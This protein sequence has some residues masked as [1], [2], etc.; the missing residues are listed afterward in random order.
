MH[1]SVPAARGSAVRSPTATEGESVPS[2]AA[3]LRSPS[4]VS[5]AA[6]KAIR[7]RMLFLRQAAVDRAAALLSVSPTS[8]KPLRHELQESP[9]PDTLLAR[10]AGLASTHELPQGALL[11]LIVRALRPARVVETG[12]GPGYSTAWILAAMDANHVGELTSLGPGSTVG[13]AAGLREVAVGQLVPPALRH[14]WTLA[15]G[16]SEEKL[17]RLLSDGGRVDLFLYDNG[18]EVARARFELR[19]A[20]ASLSGRGV[21]LAHHIDAS[22]AWAE[23]CRA[24][25]IP[26]QTLDAGPPPMGGIAIRGGPDGRA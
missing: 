12:I 14:R 20:W 6:R 5:P 25:G 15:L 26:P 22:P 18:P 9:L 19:S 17:E 4:L 1:R 13:R 11:Y 16:N 2:F 21:L 3:S 24:Q 10:G 8:M 7:Q 23:F